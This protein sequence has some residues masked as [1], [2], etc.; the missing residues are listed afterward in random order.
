MA[1]YLDDFFTGLANFFQK[2][3]AKILFWFD[4]NIVIQGGVNGAAGLTGR[5]AS[6][7]R[8]AQSGIVQNYATVFGF[9]IVGII[10][11][12]LMRS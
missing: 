2:G 12:I 1:S 11:Y 3:V 5:L 4:W 7:V 10:Y 6:F 8:K 9:G